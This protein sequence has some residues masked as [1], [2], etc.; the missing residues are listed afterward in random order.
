MWRSS[1]C[2]RAGGATWRRVHQRAPVPA[3]VPLCGWYRGLPGEGADQGSRPPAWGHH[4]TVSK[5]CRNSFSKKKG[6]RSNAVLANDVFLCVCGFQ[7][8]QLPDSCPLLVGTESVIVSETSFAE[9]RLPQRSVF[10]NIFLHSM[11][12]LFATRAYFLC[13]VKGQAI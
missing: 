11:Y 10:C 12:C 7:F 3:P 4:W 1:V 8:V 5:H 13:L 6:W 2:A 9:F